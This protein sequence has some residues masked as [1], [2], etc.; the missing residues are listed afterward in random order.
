M[1]KVNKNRQFSYLF[2][3]KIF[4]CFMYEMNKNKRLSI[5]KTFYRAGAIHL[6]PA[7]SAFRATARVVSTHFYTSDICIYPLR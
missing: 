2:L 7:K 3:L 6:L 1:Y 4:A 5:M